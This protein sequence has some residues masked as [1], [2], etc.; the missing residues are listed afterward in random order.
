MRFWEL[1]KAW[2]GVSII[3]LAMAYAVIRVAWNQ[4]TYEAPDVTTIRICHWQLESGFR[5]AL[6]NLIDDYEKSYRERTGRKIRVLQLPVS[7]RAYT[8]FVN[9]SLVGGTAPDIVE[10]GFA[11]TASD[12]TYL[13]RF[14]IPLGKY[15]E[16]PNP[17]NKGTRLEGLPWRETFFDGMESAYQRTLLDYYQVPFSMFTI[18]IYYNE[19]LY[20]KITGRREPPETFEG[21]LNACRQVKQYADRT[22]EPLVP[23]AG[24]KY[25]GNVF[26]QRYEI[27]FLFGLVRKCDDNLD[28]TASVL[29]TYRGYTRGV[30]SFQSP[31]MEASWRCM[32]DIAA[33]FQQGWLAA[34]RDDAVFM[35]VQGRSVMIASGSW[36]A[37][38]ILRQVG[39]QFKVGVF[40]F[41]MPTDNPDY[42]KYV[43]G[44]IS[45]AGIGGGIPWAITKQSRHP[46]L[47]I[48][49]LRFCT[50]RANN[51]KFNRAI[52]WLPV[53]RGAKMSGPLEPFK[54]H[55]EGFSGGFAYNISTEFGLRYEG[56]KWL[57][58]S[59]AMSPQEFGKQAQELF[60]RTGRVG[61]EDELDR[62][63]KSIRN[64]D[65]ILAAQL[66]LGYCDRPIPTIEQSEKIRQLLNAIQS[67]AH[68]FAYSEQW[69]E[70][71]KPKRGTGP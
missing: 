16:E 60:D 39:D 69:F 68:D 59:G 28:G 62:Q 44:A 3:L 34:L 67:T 29:E 47:C 56:N 5:D 31:E 10:R 63:R 11:K 38:S 8:Q 55:V 35:F 43:V 32:L 9:T 24:S 22:G 51:E 50:T 6:Q 46:D 54:P 20:L 13:A 7:E 36:D 12:P 15:V 70:Q 18:R 27:P 61:Y 42:G 66:W 30:W 2:L 14:F 49:F 25:Q 52:T 53:V 23:I 64:V 26:S 21:F 57:L 4:I 33:N 71:T 58:Y 37:S 48:D 40:D 17:Y 45:E 65:R 19:D 1:L 41:P